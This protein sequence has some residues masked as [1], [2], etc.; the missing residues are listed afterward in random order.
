MSA[1]LSHDFS[2]ITVVFS[3]AVE[4]SQPGNVFAI[5]VPRDLSTIL[6]ADFL[7]AANGG[8]LGWFTDAV[9]LQI[10]VGQNHHL[11]TLPG[12]LAG[13]F[14]C[15]ASRCAGSGALKLAALYVCRLPLIAGSLHAKNYF[16]VVLSNQPVLTLPAHPDPIV[17]SLVRHAITARSRSLI[18][19][20]VLAGVDAAI[21]SVQ[22]GVARC[23]EHARRRR[24][25]A[26]LHAHDLARHRHPGRHLQH[27]ASVRCC[28]PPLG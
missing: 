24:S 8:G 17:F 20:S 10:A 25:A 5:G 12:I 27:A 18:H 28:C 9:T 3:S 7:A 23:V 15:A 1:T 13:T 4:L 11:D 6:P 14:K 19:C 21:G 2:S 26:R 16:T 22:P